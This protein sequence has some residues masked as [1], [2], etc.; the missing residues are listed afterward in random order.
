MHAMFR[1]KWLID[2]LVVRCPAGS[3]CLR[4]RTMF[5]GALHGLSKAERVVDGQRS[6]G[7]Y[8]F[9]CQ[10]GMLHRL[11]VVVDLPQRV[12]INDT[13]RSRSMGTD[14]SR[15]SRD[16]SKGLTGRGDQHDDRITCIS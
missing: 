2:L 8:Y 9:S 3:M 7:T 5:V 15:Q 12:Q 11:M 14:T 10:D 6:R 4:Y 1:L 16:E 13:V